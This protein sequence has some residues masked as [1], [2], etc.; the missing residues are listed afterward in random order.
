V[1]GGAPPLYTREFLRACLLH[2]AGAMSFALYFLFPLY[3]KWLGGSDLTVGLVLGISTAASVAVRPWVGMLLDRVGRRRVLLWGGVANA[4]SSVPFFFLTGIGPALY[5]WM[6]VHQVVGG[7]LFAGFFTYAAD[8]TPPSRRAEGIAVFGVAGMSANGLAPFVGER[9]IAAAGYVPFFALAVGLALASTALTLTVPRRPPV[10]IDPPSIRHVLGLA[11]Q[12]AL[13][14]VLLVT[15]VLGVAI[16]AAYF[17]VAPFAREVGVMI[18]GPFFLAYSATSIVIRLFGLRVLDALGPHR[19]A[20]PGFVVFAV[21][22]AGLAF[23]PLAASATPLLIVCG[24]ACGYGHGSLFPVLN[25]LAVSRAP[26]EKQGAVVGLHT[27]A[28][29][30]GAV[31]GTPL[32]GFLAETVGYPT[33]YRV[34]A[35]ASLGGVVL[36][37]RDARR[38]RG[39]VA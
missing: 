29:D 39:G 35:L 24:M 38:V 16:E 4:C 33:M 34:V 11:V 21:G 32:C 23:L 25:A 10:A 20:Y 17:F 22:L 2:F 26:R 30:L 15:V 14:M 5:L 6:T 31:L 36:M 9:I 27:G 18:V 7:A 28:L 12:P 1:S 13:S 37:G 19:V 3:V 8:L